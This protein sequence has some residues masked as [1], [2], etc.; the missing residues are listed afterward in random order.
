MYPAEGHVLFP[1]DDV[2]C[3]TF[4]SRLGFG[5]RLPTDIIHPWLF[6]STIFA[7]AKKRIKENYV[8]SR[9]SI[10]RVA[11]SVCFKTRLSAKP[12]VWKWIFY[13]HA[14]KTHFQK[15][16]FSLT[17]VFKVR[18]FEYWSGLFGL[19]L[20][21]LNLVRAFYAYKIGPSPVLG[22]NSFTW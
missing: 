15:M 13:Y 6:V 22:S 7:P 18:D 14:N 5:S 20:P 17:L 3:I 8:N 16:G 11:S 1:A 10:G 9:L 19:S 2:S 12:L 4:G 21:S